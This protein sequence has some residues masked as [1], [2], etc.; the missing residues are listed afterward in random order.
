MTETDGLSTIALDPSCVDNSE[1][2]KF[3]RRSVEA[4]EL[5]C[6]TVRR[7]VR[8]GTERVSEGVARDDRPFAPTARFY[9]GDSRSSISSSAGYCAEMGSV[10]GSRDK[11][12]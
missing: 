6:A 7:E 1:Q 2:E 8:L 11:W 4:D 12:W 3:R 5:F 10:V 9:P